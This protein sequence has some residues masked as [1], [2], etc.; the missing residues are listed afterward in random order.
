MTTNPLIRAPSL[1]RLIIIAMALATLAV[2]VA[3]ARAADGPGFGLR[4]FTGDNPSFLVFHTANCG[5][6]RKA[7]GAVAYDRGWRLSVQIHPF[8]GF[9]PYAL[10][11]GR[12]NGTFLA[13]IS[14]SGTEY[15][16]D[17]IPPHHIPSGG[18]ISFSNHGKTMG[19]GFYP[20]FTGDGSDAV[21]VAGG[22]TCHYPKHRRR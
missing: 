7:F 10:V 11:R 9:H 17:F 14:P 8:T 5:I 4:V 22:L 19:G 2:P 21:G 18:Q 16:S 6:R 12:Y 15:A 20:M 1:R 13:L 3:G